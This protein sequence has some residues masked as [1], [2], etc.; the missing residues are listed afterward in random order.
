MVTREGDGPG[1]GVRERQGT[2]HTDRQGA[3]KSQDAESQA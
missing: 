1:E 3:D 2:R